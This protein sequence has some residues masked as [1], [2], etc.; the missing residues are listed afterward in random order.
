[1]GPH[2]RAQ[3]HVCLREGLCDSQLFGHHRPHEH[4]TTP[5]GVFGQGMDRHINPQLK[6]IE[7]QARTPG[8]VQG[9]QAWT[10]ARW[11]V[12]SIVSLS[13]LAQTHQVRKLHG[14]RTC[15]LQPHQA[16]SFVQF[17]TE[18]SQ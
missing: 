11:R 6:G 16:S 18:V 8:V 7:G 17:G 4:I 10:P 15:R 13:G 3:V 5:T 9:D 12:P 2:T 1:M 14:D